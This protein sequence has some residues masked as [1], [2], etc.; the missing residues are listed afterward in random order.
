MRVLVTGVTGQLGYDVCQVLEERG[1]E[2][3]GVGSAQLDI[4][5]DAAVSA[6]LDSYHPDAVIHC[7]AYTAVDRAEDEVEC[8]FAVNEGGTR[9]IARACKVVDAKLLY[10]STDYVFP[11]GGER[12]YEVNDLIG[13]RNVYGKSKLAG[14]I[15]A[16]ETLERSQIVRTSRV[17]GLNGGN[18]VKTMSSLFVPDTS[19]T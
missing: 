6:Y 7:A 15:A 16:V 11:G 10:L 3:Q 2:H 13:P 12:F 18:F 4:T 1:V 5:N 9:N 19:S 8:C 14:E 17:F